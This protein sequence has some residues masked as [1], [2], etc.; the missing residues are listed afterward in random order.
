MLYLPNKCG[1]C[2]CLT[3]A[4]RRRRKCWNWRSHL[5]L[6]SFFRHSKLG[7]AKQSHPC[8]QIIATRIHTI[9]M[10]IIIAITKIKIK[11]KRIKQK[12]K[13]SEYNEMQTYF[14]KQTIN[15]S[16]ERGVCSGACA[17]E[18]KARFWFRSYTA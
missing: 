14:F 4:F 16:R 2:S 9:R 1:F 18:E 6:F 10:N 17:C 15:E 13:N 8:R 5:G 12:N 11:K 3:H 7:Y